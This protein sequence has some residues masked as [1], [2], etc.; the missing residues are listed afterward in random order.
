MPRPW[1]RT[2]TTSCSGSAHANTSYSPVAVGIGVQHGVGAGLG[3]G[4]RDVGA[5]LVAPAE[6]VDHPAHHLAGQR[7]A[8]GV[9]GQQQLDVR[10]VGGRSTA[11]CSHVVARP[12]AASSPR[13]ILRR[14]PCSRPRNTLRVADGLA[15]R[16]PRVG[17]AGALAQRLEGPPDEARDVHLG[18]ADR[19]RDLRLGEALLEAQVRGSRARARAGRPGR[20]RASRGPRP[21]RSPAS[22]TPDRRCPRPPRPREPGEASGA[23]RWAL[24]A[25]RASR[26]SSIDRPVHSAISRTRRAAAVLGRELADGVGDLRAGLLD[27]ARHAHGPRAVAEVAADLAEDRRRREARELEAALG[28][29]AV[30]R[31]DQADRARPGRGRRAARRGPRSGARARAPA[32]GARR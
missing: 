9:G 31:L 4:D 13:A 29:E 14:F 28:L 15:H 18:D 19:V 26:T 17:T 25:A 21:A 5:A 24:P 20:R 16:A 11:E 8:L 23:G 6:D 12:R 2:A 1:S 3:D 7:D 32:G 27:A 22:S 30:D 10:A